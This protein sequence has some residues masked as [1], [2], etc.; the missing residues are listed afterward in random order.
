MATATYALRHRHPRAPPSE[1]AIPSAPCRPSRFRRRRPLPRGAHGS[2]GGAALRRGLVGEPADGDEGAAVGVH[3]V[4]AGGGDLPGLP[5]S[6]LPWPSMCCH[7]CGSCWTAIKEPALA[8]ISRAP[9]AATHPA[10]P[11]QL[12][13]RHPCAAAGRSLRAD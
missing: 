10:F 12:S 1:H 8:S 5:R 7:D 4:R 3:L 13:P 2:G 11:D 9:A 6:T